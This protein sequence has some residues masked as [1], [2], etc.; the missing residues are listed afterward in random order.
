MTKRMGYKEALD[1]IMN[2]DDTDWLFDE[3]SQAPSVTT[4]LVADIYQNGDTDKVK[5]DLLRRH[6]GNK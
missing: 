5:V 4:C 2:N 6:R 1:W 3:E